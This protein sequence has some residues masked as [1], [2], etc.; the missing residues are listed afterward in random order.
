[1]CGRVIQKSRPGAL[2]LAIVDGFDDHRTKSGDDDRWSNVPPR[3]NGAPSQDLWIIR[4]HPTTGERSLDLLRWGLVPHFCAER[5]KP[6]PINAA[7]E[8]LAAKTFPPE[9]RPFFAEAYRKRRCIM[10]IDGFFEWKAVKGEK[11]KQPF[12][13]AMRDGSPFGLGALWENWRDP[14]TGEWLRTFSV[15][16]TRANSLVR[17]IH[18]RMP[19]ILSPS[20]YARWLSD[21]ED[22]REL[23]KA[24]PSEPM[25]MWPVSTRVNS[26]KND[27]PE[28][29]EPALEA[30]AAAPPDGNS[31]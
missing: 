21:E 24:H 31:A 23:L 8:T 2:S 1:M 11:V 4:R 12:A 9:T 30:N 18:S 13:I 17:Q 16:T 28:I 14:K 22:P 3:Y 20:D 25:T 29:I 10:P 6:P 5:P 26:P 27:D 19:L 7:A 15:V